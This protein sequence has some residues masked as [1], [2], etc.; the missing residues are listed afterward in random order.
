MATPKQISW[1]GTIDR[2]NKEL[3]KGGN[4][5]AVSKEFHDKVVNKVHK[6]QDNEYEDYRI[7]APLPISHQQAAS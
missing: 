7:S 3:K 6:D 4:P 2:Y 1:Q 5:R